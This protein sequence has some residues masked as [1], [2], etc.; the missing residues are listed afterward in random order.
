MTHQ[1]YRNPPMFHSS[2]IQAAAPPP[3]KL[4]VA[5]CSTEGCN[6]IG[7][8]RPNG[9]YY[10]FE[11][12]RGRLIPHVC[13]CQAK[14]TEADLRPLYSEWSDKLGE[15]VIFVYNRVSNK[16][17]QY[18]CR[19][20]FGQL[21]QVE[22]SG[23]IYN[24]GF[25]SQ[26]NIIASIDVGEKF[27]LIER[28]SNGSMRKQLEFGDR[29]IYLPSTDVRTILM[30]EVEE[31]EREKEEEEEYSEDQDDS[32]DFEDEENEDSAYEDY[33]SRIPEF[34]ITICLATN[35][36]IVNVFDYGSDT[37][38]C[39]YY[40]ERTGNFH[41]FTC[42]TCP[43]T[44]VEDHLYPKYHE[45]A[46]DGKYVIH[47]FNSFTRLMEKYSCNTTTKCFEQLTFVIT[48]Q[49]VTAIMRDS[50]GRIKKEQFSQVK[51]QFVKMPPAP[52]QTF[53]VMRREVEKMKKREEAS[54]KKKEEELKK[55]EVI[56]DSKISQ[57]LVFCG[58]SE[59]LS[60]Q[61]NEKIPKDVPK[62]S[63]DHSETPPKSAEIPINL[64]TQENPPKRNQ[65]EVSRKQQDLPN[66]RN[67]TDT[68]LDAGHI[69]R[70]YFRRYKERKA[71]EAEK[72]R[73]KKE[74]EREK[75]MKEQAFQELESKR[76]ELES[77]SFKKRLLAAIREKRQELAT[78]SLSSIPP[79]I[80]KEEEKI[81]EDTE[82]QRLIVPDVSSDFPEDSDAENQLQCPVKAP[83]FRFSTRVP[84]E[85]QQSTSDYYKQ[86]FAGREAQMEKEEIE[87]FKKREEEELK[88]LEKQP[89]F[90]KPQ[91]RRPVPPTIR[92][93]KTA[94]PT[95]K[96]P[97][98]EPQPT[99]EELESFAEQF[100][101]G[102]PSKQES[103][104][105]SSK[106]NPSQIPKDCSKS[107]RKK[108]EISKKDDVARLQQFIEEISLQR[109]GKTDVQESLLVEN[110]YPFPDF[111]D[112]DE[113]STSS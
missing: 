92:L 37:Y 113:E 7:V 25:S 89:S 107:S 41:R 79:Q 49:P 66:P 42:H 57:P 74:E 96:S 95:H 27:I 103:N 88:A 61:G 67:S 15:T 6:V 102:I 23:L 34:S 72:E 83:V 13:S 75:I 85:S 110:S 64:E 78:Q 106:R 109:R 22:K 11:H 2:S 55:N 68:K 32:S 108:R 105:N 91:S 80:L 53:I 5:E 65:E 40:E 71:A 21:E 77:A 46:E 43:K 111:E 70:E 81:V 76:R 44:V 101:S 47:V 19:E 16:V 30:N 35:R 59:S 90:V 24:S 58:S 33:I 31:M 73:L 97:E 63:S 87:R 36:E 20:E 82:L 48:G 38:K 112:T 98:S 104:E 54:K 17:E 39:F 4:I 56:S 28:D 52:V 29:F 45:V 8:L 50:D 86:F 94:Q 26:S 69:I 84:E 10:L 51:K 99:E 1:A 14:T 60:A 93:N 62:S 3:P 12:E 18:V 9:F 100:Y